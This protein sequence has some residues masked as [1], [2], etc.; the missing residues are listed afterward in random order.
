MFIFI[1]LIFLGRVQNK[2]MFTVKEKVKIFLYSFINSIITSI[3][4]F[5]ILNPEINPLIKILLSLL[6]AIFS[7]I[8]YNYNSNNK[9]D[10]YWYLYYITY[11]ISSLILIFIINKSF[12]VMIIYLLLFF[13]PFLLTNL[14]LYKFRNSI[15]NGVLLFLLYY[16]FSYN[17]IFI[18]A[19]NTNAYIDNWDGI[20]ILITDIKPRLSNI[21]ISYI[22]KYTLFL[23][24]LLIKM[25]EFPGIKLIHKYIIKNSLINW[26]KIYF[27][28]KNLFNFKPPFQLI[29]LTLISFSILF[30]N[31]MLIKLIY[32]HKI[33]INICLLF[34]IIYFITGLLIIAFMI[35]QKLNISYKW[36]IIFICFYLCLIFVLPFQLSILSL[37]F[38][39]VLGIM[40]IW[41]N[42]RKN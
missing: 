28:W 22:L 39:F 27:N 29:L 19:D 15:F 20:V 18:I 16:I 23:L 35:M 11:F 24:M 21:S 26:V 31:L 10:K 25:M 5:Y 32:I 38:P 2:K 4:I 8:L 7:Y 12:W 13:I 34:S 36:S 40:D 30:L 3:L 33:I 41:F 14:K 9:I 37:C 17:I 1:I 42:F 6:N